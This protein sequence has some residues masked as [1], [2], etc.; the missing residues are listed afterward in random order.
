[1]PFR[2]LVLKVHSRCDLACDHCYVYEH[3][4]Q[5][6]RD[7]PKVMSQE[8]LAW[9]AARLAEHP[10]TH[11]LDKVQVVLHGGEPPLAGPDR[12]R[13]TARTLRDGVSDVCDLDLHIHTDGLLDEAYCRVSGDEGVL[14]GVSVDG[15]AEAHDRHRRYADSQ[16]SYQQVGRAIGLPRTEPYR[17]LYAGL[18][19]TIDLANDPVAVYEALVALEPPRIEF[20]LPHATWDHPPGRPPGDEAAYAD[21]LLAIFGRWRAD[22]RPVPVRLF[23]SVI[24]TTLGGASLTEATGLKLSDLVVETD[25]TYEQADSLKTAFDG[26]PITGLDLVHHDLDGVARHPGTGTRQRGLAGLCATCRACPVV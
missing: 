8:T 9:T 2:H 5:S 20:L 26:T 15:Y 7:R 11:R 1:M 13:E 25:G 22:G 6:W 24:S 16:G 14:A 19:C 18:L 3:L 10:K 17:H 21:W 4:D 12:L 23:D